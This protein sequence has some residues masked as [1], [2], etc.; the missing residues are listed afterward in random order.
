MPSHTKKER[1]KRSLGGQ[2]KVVGP[3]GPTKYLGHFTGEKVLRDGHNQLGFL[4]RVRELFRGVP[5][6]VAKRLPTKK[7]APEKEPGRLLGGPP[8]GRELTEE[9]KGLF[10]GGFGGSAAMDPVTGLRRP[11]GTSVF[12]RKGR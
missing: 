12:R 7:A 8:P 9:G 4:R 2:P 5:A 1:V 3:D 10:F 11:I 6:R